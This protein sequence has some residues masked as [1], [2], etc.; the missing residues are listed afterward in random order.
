MVSVCQ[1]STGDHPGQQQYER[2]REKE[3]KGE[4]IAEHAYQQGQTCIL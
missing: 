1:P 3:R 4:D 2:P